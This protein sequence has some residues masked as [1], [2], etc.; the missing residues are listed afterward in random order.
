[1]CIMR[2]GREG[3]LEELE[4]GLQL[5]AN[6]MNSKLMKVMKNNCLML[7]LMCAILPLG[8]HY[9]KW[10]ELS[11]CWLLQAMNVIMR[12]HTNARQ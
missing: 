1:M 9:W 4:M 2:G 7:T 11:M 12:V 3:A 8:H 10:H 5:S 6:S